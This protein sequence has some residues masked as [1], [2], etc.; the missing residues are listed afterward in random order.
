MSVGLGAGGDKDGPAG[1]SECPLGP[2]E[3]S[4]EREKGGPGGGSLANALEQRALHVLFMA[5]QSHQSPAPAARPGTASIIL[6][7]RA[8]LGLASLRSRPLSQPGVGC[9]SRLG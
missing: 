6:P 5:S 9:S 2:G 3:P 4:Q 7:S 1:A 8:I